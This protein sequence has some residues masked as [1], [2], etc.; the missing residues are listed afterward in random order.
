MTVIVVETDLRHHARIDSCDC[1]ESGHGTA[2]EAAQHA[3]R[4]VRALRRREMSVKAALRGGCRV[5]RLRL[6]DLRKL[7]IHRR[8]T[9]I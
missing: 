3:W 1:C 8:R 5:P 2:L 6:A 4:L 9:K 7:T